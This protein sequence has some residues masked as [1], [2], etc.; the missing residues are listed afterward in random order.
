MTSRFAVAKQKLVDDIVNVIADL[1]GA[2]NAKAK[3]RK[4][5][6]WNVTNPHRAKAKPSQMIVWL[7]GARRGGWTDF[8]GGE[9]GDAIDLVAYVLEGIIHADSRMRAVEWAEDRYGLKKLDPATRA[10]MAAQ[11]AEQKAKMEAD[12]ADRRKGNRDRA[13]KMFFAAD[14]KILGTPVEGYLAARGI[15]LADVPYITPAFRYQKDCEYWLGGER[16]G[17]GRKIGRTP[18]FPAMVSAMV[19]ADG[20]LNACH[21]TYIEPDGSDKLATRRRGY[22]DDDGR[23]LSAKL[24]WPEVA[25]FVVRVTNGPSGLSM[26]QAAAAGRADWCGVTEGIEDAFSSGIA[27]PE[28]RMLAAGSLSGLLHVPDH[29]AVKGWIIFKDN[30]WGKPQAAALFNRAVARIRSFKKPVEIVAMPAD[31]GKDVNEASNQE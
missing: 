8:T 24:M 7:T 27:D 31:W 15:L 29:A 16:D 19:S 11:A 5:S 12:E 28:L 26:E 6:G 14:A 30:D 18:R 4:P 10:K 2:A 13:R 21:L 3:H 17:E 22:V 20:T 25:G 9:K 1:F 23:A